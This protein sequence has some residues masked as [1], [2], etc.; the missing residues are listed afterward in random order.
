MARPQEIVERWLA[1]FNAHDEEGLRRWYS[2]DATF[3]A[4]GD[5][6]LQGADATADYAMAWLRAFPDAEM[7]IETRVAEGEWVAERFLF[8]GTHDGVLASA[9]GDLP[10][11]GRRLVGR[12]AQV[13]RVE[14]DEITEGYL[15]F[16][17]ME[18]LA[19]LGL[20]PEVARQ[21]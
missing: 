16:D 19:Q 14:G 10:P 3:E 11:T 4:P 8:E 21:T 12:G 15:Y 6:R 13:T 17:Q 18:V 1:A 20:I 7:Q 5:V 9:A 2:D